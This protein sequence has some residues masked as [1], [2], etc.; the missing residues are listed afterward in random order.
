MIE[1]LKIVLLIIFSTVTFPISAQD[2]YKK[3]EQSL[4]DCGL[5]IHSKKIMSD[6]EKL[7]IETDSIVSKNYS[8]I[9][10][11]TFNSLIDISDYNK[12]DSLIG[13]NCNGLEI[14]STQR[15]KESYGVLYC[16]V[17]KNPNGNPYLDK[18]VIKYFDNIPLLLIYSSIM[19][20]NS[21]NFE[22][23]ECVINKIE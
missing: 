6:P 11:V 14:L 4:I 16:Y 19:G 13:P 20:N 3:I 9:T 5:L 18:C 23:F 15:I 2:Y 17:Y 21:E 1:R 8:R 10:V 7:I 22:R 12:V